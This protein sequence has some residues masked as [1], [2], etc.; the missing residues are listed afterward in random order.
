MQVKRKGLVTLLRNMFPA[1]VLVHYFAHCINLCLQDAIVEY[2]S[3]LEIPLM[4]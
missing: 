3:H 4:S 2:L 1:T